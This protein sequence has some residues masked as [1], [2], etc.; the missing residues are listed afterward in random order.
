MVPAL[1]SLGSL[2][3]MLAIDT[4]TTSRIPVSLNETLGKS[5]N[6]Y[7][8]IT[9]S[10]VFVSC[11]PETAQVLEVSLAKNVQSGEVM[12][13]G[14]SKKKDENLVKGQLQE[15]HANEEDDESEESYAYVT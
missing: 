4:L 9:L 11:C 3:S 2:P 6:G 13:G 5:T 15:S 10:T 8:L 1:F 7:S 14:V 12:A